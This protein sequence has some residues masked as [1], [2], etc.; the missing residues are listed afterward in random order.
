M[1]QI[2]IIVLFDKKTM[3]YN[4]QILSLIERNYLFFKV[5]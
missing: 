5:L 2:I 3:I 1:G 4:I